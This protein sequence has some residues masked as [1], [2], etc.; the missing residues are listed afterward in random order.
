MARRACAARIQRLSIASLVGAL[1]LAATAPMAAQGTDA[2]SAQRLFQAA[3][4]AYQ[5]KT[6]D[7]LAR[8]I[9]EWDEAAQRYG[10][11]GKATEKARA[12]DWSC[13]ALRDA[14]RRDDALERCRRALH[15]YEELGVPTPQ[16]YLQQ[17]IGEFHQATNQHDS[18]LVHFR[19]AAELYRQA[20]NAA[21]EGTALSRVGATLYRAGRTDSAF[22]VFQ[23]A[24]QSRRL[25]YDTTG[26][27]AAHEWMGFIEFE[28]KRYAAA[29]QEERQSLVLYAARGSTASA[30][31]LERMLGRSFS[32]LGIADSSMVHLGR[33]LA[34][35][36]L[37][38][39]ANDEARALRELGNLLSVEGKTDSALTIYRAARRL[40]V[41]GRDR[42]A[43]AVVQRNIGMMFDRLAQV[44]SAAVS[45]YTAAELY[46]AAGDTANLMST[47]GWIGAIEG[48]RG[49][50][51]AAISAFREALALNPAKGADAPR[52]MFHGQLALLFV[53]Q[54][55]LDSA[56]LHARIAKAADPSAL[57]PDSVI[58]ADRR[59]LRRLPADDLKNVWAAMSKLATDFEKFG[60]KDSAEAWHRTAFTLKR[61]TGD[62]SGM[63]VELLGLAN[64]QAARFAY[65]TARRSFRAAADILRAK[66]SES[67]SLTLFI[68]VAQLFR[69]EGQLDSAL[70]TGRDVLR[71]WR[72]IGNRTEVASA[73][74]ILAGFHMYQSQLDSV[75]ALSAE[76]LATLPATTSLQTAALLYATR[77][78]AFV[79]LGRY[80]SAVANI[81]RT[82]P[83]WEQAGDDVKG[84]QSLGHVGSIYRALGQFDSAMTYHRKQRTVGERLGSNDLLV[85]AVRALAT[86]F[87]D[88]GASD[89]AQRTFRE[90]QA[91]SARAGD[92]RGEAL[93]LQR[94]G[95]LQTRRGV[96]DSA[97][98]SLVAALA[99]ARTSPRM[100]V[101]ASGLTDLADLFERAGERDSAI[102]TYQQARVMAGATGDRVLE[103]LALSAIGRIE[104]N[105]GHLKAGLEA[106]REALAR[107]RSNGS[108]ETSAGLLARIAYTLR[109]M[110]KPDLVA[111]VSM[112]DTA[113]AYR[114][115]VRRE[116]G[117]DE[118]RLSVG[119]QT[120]LPAGDWELAWLERAR[121]IGAESAALGALAA[122]ERTR[123]QA[124]LDLMR[125]ASAVRANNDDFVAMG[126]RLVGAV[127]STG[128][129]M[130]SYLVT[131]DTLITWYAYPG[132]PLVVRT[133][134]VTSDSLAT[135]IR[136]WRRALRADGA[137]AGGASRGI[138]EAPRAGTAATNQLAATLGLKLARLLL[139][140]GLR[141]PG[142]TRELVIVPHASLALVPFGAL[143]LGDTNTV[144]ASRYALRYA[145]S[146][147]SLIEA[148]RGRAPMTATTRRAVLRQ[149]LVV[150][151]PRM[152]T[153]RSADGGTVLLPSLPA[154]EREAQVVAHRVGANFLSDTAA[155][156]SEVRR[157]MV[158]APLI[159]LATHGYAYS[160]A[161]Q[162]RNSFVALAAD[163]AGDGLLTVGEVLDGRPLA[164]ELV[165]LSA[166]QTGLGNMAQAEG[167]VG[168]QRAFLARGARSL[169][170]S[171]WSVSDD[172]TALLMDRFYLHWLSDADAP[173][174][175]EALRRAQV[176]VRRTKGFEEPRYWAAFQLVGGR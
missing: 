152:P 60:M 51:E 20:G 83:L 106:T 52:K 37:I 12:L 175:S 29:V 6:P 110:P 24:V 95:M 128:A 43:E 157:R 31:R 42:S 145:P 67:Q 173:V 135:L 133:V 101:E 17:R 105:R 48:K 76:A 102:V 112:F 124:L 25:A 98:A 3:R 68:R 5:L 120:S 61:A 148:E 121:A 126:R 65:D 103:T 118:N 131:P 34:P 85:A 28:R 130:L 70:S 4:A 117:G 151:N 136:Q 40:L 59:E 15:Q 111:V 58:A 41:R 169:L 153:P 26:E 132:A 10:Q 142:R 97:A 89:S 64:L 140:E 123:A 137:N 11:A 143:P 104:T 96:V 149:A 172:A 170:V 9:A 32:A 46:R 21:G 116:A 16:G 55:Q 88:A 141:Q 93:A 146:L 166:C 75:L 162:A 69:E 57:P 164:A 122:T 81:K 18:A 115:A 74:M 144:L 168:L 44:D 94:I 56:A 7:G 62:S 107:E 45:M 100:R 79:R 119:V 72:R 138:E 134:A 154:A 1:S 171:L 22:A 99:R 167:T 165:V 33:S 14:G 13:V 82:V 8:A 90:M 91:L 38:S 50:T 78:V 174:K 54:G 30:R 147:S 150:G 63:V 139:P 86:D 113:A 27:A 114:A 160:T 80:D 92:A 84:A 66:G 23:D 109:R 77:G 125:G 108:L 163:S 176:D 158:T 36:S 156:E 39:D 19:A 49:R 127:T 129:A 35:D 161:S 47:E 159:H 53:K 87:E 155:T 73:L 71:A 2:D